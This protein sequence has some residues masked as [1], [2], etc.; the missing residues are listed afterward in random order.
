MQEV[1]KMSKEIATK[2]KGKYYDTDI[3]LKEYHNNMMNDG[4]TV[5]MQD[6]KKRLNK[7]FGKRGEKK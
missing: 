7:V 4:Y 2:M 1:L 3:A 5:L 6:M